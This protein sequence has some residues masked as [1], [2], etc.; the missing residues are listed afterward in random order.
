MFSLQTVAIEATEK[1]ANLTNDTNGL[2]TF[3]ECAFQGGVYNDPTLF[4]IMLLV[5]FSYLGMKMNLP[6]SVMF[7]FAWGVIYALWVTYDIPYLQA[8]LFLGVVAVGVNLIV[9]LYM[10]GKRAT[11]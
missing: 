5:L 10:G 6:F 1:C 4:V 3:W 11:Q 8:L 9:S 2:A 7:I